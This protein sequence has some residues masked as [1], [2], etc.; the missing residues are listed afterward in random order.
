MDPLWD[1]LYQPL[2]DATGY[3]LGQLVGELG[4]EGADV[5]DVGVDV[6]EVAVAAREAAH[7]RTVADELAVERSARPRW[8]SVRVLG[9]RSRLVQGRGSDRRRE[10]R[11]S[12]G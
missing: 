10:P 6:E 8:P 12:R 7:A 11:E 4:F 9:R 1:A 2:V 5:V 3:V